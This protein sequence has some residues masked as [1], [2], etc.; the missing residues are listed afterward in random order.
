KRVDDDLVR[1]FA[2]LVPQLSS[3][4]PPNAEE[5]RQIVESPASMLL[6]ARD[7]TA[8]RTIVGTLTLV[9]YRIPTGG[10]A[11]IED[12]V[13]DEAARG[14]GVGETLCRDAIERARAA[15]AESVS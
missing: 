13:V 12:V 8:G 14:R 9:L 7:E 15:G 2:R 6:V 4:P 3:A 10:R 5:L 1:A 11:Y